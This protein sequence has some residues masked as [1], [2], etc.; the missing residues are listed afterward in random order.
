MGTRTRPPSV[1]GTV[2]LRPTAAQAYPA[3]LPQGI[4]CEVQLNLDTARSAVV[5]TRRGARGGGLSGDREL[6]VR[7]CNAMA[8]HCAEYRFV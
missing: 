8:A 3:T 7:R 5:G 4:M 2:T 6:K 1:R